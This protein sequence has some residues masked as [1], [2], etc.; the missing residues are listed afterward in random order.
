MKIKMVVLT[1]LITIVLCVFYYVSPENA[2]A[3]ISKD[4]TVVKEPAARNLEITQNIKLAE[5]DA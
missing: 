2:T 5:T 4:T 1:L 3:N